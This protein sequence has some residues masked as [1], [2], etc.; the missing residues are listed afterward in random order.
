MVTSVLSSGPWG[1]RDVDRGRSGV[2]YI[3][4]SGHFGN[5]RYFRNSRHFGNA[6]CIG[7]RGHFGNGGL[8]GD[9]GRVRNVQARWNCV[10]DIV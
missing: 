10:R 4:N 7:N 2:W 8:L 9:G 3:E 6:G 1:G 5:S